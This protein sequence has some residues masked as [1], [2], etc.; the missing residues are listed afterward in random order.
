M[1]ESS[2]AK[3][4]LESGHGLPSAVVS[5]DELVEVDLE[6]TAADA[7]VG[8]NQ[9]LLEVTDGSVARGTTDLAPLRN[10]GPQGLS[11][12]DMLE[13][14]LFQTRERLEPIG[15]NSRTGSHVLG[16]ETVDGVGFEVGDDGHPETP[17]GFSPLLDGDQHKRCPTPLELTAS[18]NTSLGSAHPGVV[19][20]DFVAKRF[21]SQ[22]DHG[23]PKL[24]EHHPGG[25][26]TS[27]AKLALEQQCRDTPF[28]GG[29]QVGCPEPQGQRRLRI[30]KDG[31]RGQRDLMTTG[32][33]F[34]AFSSHQRVAVTVCAARTDEPL[35]P[36]TLSQVFLAGLFGGVFNLKLAECRRKGWTWHP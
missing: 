4:S 22:V 32:G 10:F 11:A 3:E 12:G 21:A 26:V 17:R 5:E 2:K 14:S 31:P 16:E 33:A 28:I 13:T 15:V 36:A 7:M 19:N 24:M 23:S 6:L 27:N 34:P 35:R 29:H 8:A 30:M 20:F 25:F 9:P 18:S 1:V